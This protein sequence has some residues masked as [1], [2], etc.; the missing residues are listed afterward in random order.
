MAKSRRDSSYSTQNLQGDQPMS[1]QTWKVAEAIGVEQARTLDEVLTLLDDVASSHFVTLFGSSES[2][3]A[4]LGELTAVR[5]L[6]TPARR[7]LVGLV[8]DAVELPT[9]IEAWQHMLFCVLDKLAESVHAPQET[10][11]GLRRQL[12]EVT[13]QERRGDDSAAFAAAAFA[14]QFRSALPGL[15]DVAYANTQQILT[16]GLD[17]LDQVDGVFAHDLLEASRYFMNTQNCAV[18]LAADESRLLENLRI[19]LPDGEQILANWPSERIAVPERS[20]PAQKRTA[21]RDAPAEQDTPRRARPRSDALAALPS[22]AARVLRDALTP[23]LRAVDA[24][25]AEW[26]SA[27]TA[28]QKRQKDGVSMRISGAQ[29][30]KL[31]ALKAL[32]PRLFDAARLDVALLTRLERAA[33][34]GTVDMSDELQRLMALNPQLTAL[35]KSAP[36]FIGIEGRDIATTLRI[37]TGTSTGEFTAPSQSERKA[38]AQRRAQIAVARPSAA[39]VAAFFASAVAIVS[40]DQVSK[41]MSGVPPMLPNA[42]TSSLISNSIMLGMEL[43][44]LA[45]SLLILF[46]WGVAR[47]SRLYQ[48]AFGLITGGLGSNLF[49]HVAQG[50]VVNFLP[51][52]NITLNV[53][54]FGL[55]AGAF[56]LLISL[57]RPNGDMVELTE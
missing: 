45:L 55:L 42:T 34:A 38:P 40:A 20:A 57:F 21:L 12:E 50:G 1:N 15:L 11:I 2:A 32:S 18:L 41:I 28:L 25:C 49:D 39:P 31:I 44:G 37:L 8:V 56:L 27:T 51:L 4:L 33:R 9:H 7:R 13:R 43:V 26:Q 54:H 17:K 6:R 19:A 16:I 29:V 47:R 23:D 3:S 36:N 52:G 48:A 46:F 22:D 10:V 5:G 53:A 30:A 14:Q 35:F 24:A